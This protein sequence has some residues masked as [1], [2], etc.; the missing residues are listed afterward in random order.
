MIPVRFKRLLAVI[1]LLPLPI[2]AA[3]AVRVTENPL[4]G[5]WQGQGVCVAQV[6]VKAPGQFQANL[7]R[8][9]DEPGA[10]PIAVL[11]GEAASD[12]VRFSGEGWSGALT[13]GRFIGGKDGERFDLK[14]VTRQ[15]PT[16]NAKPPIGAVVLF[17]GKNLDAWAKQKD[18]QWLEPDGPV[19]AWKLADGAVE[20]AP[21]SG[22]IIT[23]QAFGD[24]KLHAEFRTLGPVNSGIFLQSRYEIGI[25]ESYGRLD[26]STCGAL[27]NA[28]TDAPARARATLPAFQWQTFDIEFRTPRF[29]AAGTKTASARVTVLL[30]GVMLYEQ[31]ELQLPKGAARRL[32]EAAT[33]PLM[34]QEH[35]E[36]IQFRNIWLVEMGK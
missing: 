5:D 25:N 14:R 24:F 32:G 16:L 20:S 4:V 22:S 8:K 31:H 27:G 11:L 10:K 12:T 29:D 13:G 18:R 19:T 26:G 21:G 34:L 6:F 30:N 1:G 2:L 7:L 15:P 9:F 35:G 3:D 36:P 28:P 33:G 17:D 23:K